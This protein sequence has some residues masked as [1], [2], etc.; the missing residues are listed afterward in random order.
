MY[1]LF[2]GAGFSKWAVSLPLVNELFDFNVAIFNRTDR[3]RIEN[4]KSL[5]YSWDRLHPHA[6]NEQFVAFALGLTKK[7]RD[8]VLWYVVRRLSE[9]FIWEEFHAQRWRRHVLMIDENRKFRV[10]GLAQAGDFLEG[11]LGLS[12]AGIITTNYD[13]V[14][15][16]ALGTKYFN[17]GIPDQVLVGRGPYPVSTWRQPVRLKGKVRLAK[18]HG[19]VSW[20]MSGYYTN[21]RR[22]ITGN[23]LIVA[24]TSK[25]D[26]PKNLEYIWN[27]AGR[28]LRQ[29]RKLL[30]F[31]FAF[32]EYDQSVLD[33]LRLNG[34]KIES[35]LLVDIAPNLKVASQL[36]PKATITSCAPPPDGSS[37]IYSWKMSL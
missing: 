13:L 22:S 37:L 36:W 26:I 35:V 27:L 8:S 18:I 31:G 25:T 9:P 24:P 4:A 32:N 19:S 28:I 15:E 2:L 10:K 14:I 33:L 29:S 12:T 3:N 5:K 6:N 1:S 11:F 17:Y 30:V 21:G 20:D 7:Q 16:Y 23:A 34:D